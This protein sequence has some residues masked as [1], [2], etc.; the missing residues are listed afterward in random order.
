MSQHNDSEEREDQPGEPLSPIGGTPFPME[1]I[2]HPAEELGHPT[3]AQRDSLRRRKKEW[4]IVTW[5][6]SL[7]KREAHCLITGGI[8]GGIAVLILWILVAL[9]SGGR[10]PQVSKQIPAPEARTQEPEAEQPKA[11]GPRV[12]TAGM[13]KEAPAPEAAPVT[14]A[15]EAPT[16]VAP[17]AEAPPKM[18]TEPVKTAA[19]PPKPVEPVFTA[20]AGVELTTIVSYKLAGKPVAQEL[21][22]VIQAVE[23]YKFAAAEGA[24]RVYNRSTSAQGVKSVTVSAEGVTVAFIAT[25][26]PEQLDRLTKPVQS[27]ATALG[28]PTEG[29]WTATGSSGTYKFK[30]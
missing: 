30:K 5:A 10:E 27:L 28:L 15:P 20:T 14:K 8:T 21:D 26:S 19:E 23:G 11:K 29:T 24:E 12:L 18:V 9:L 7:S 25:P 3:R 4:A 6:R 22:G 2:A 17:P 1:G 16:T 13:T